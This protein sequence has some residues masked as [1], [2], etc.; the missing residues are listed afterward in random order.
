MN[1]NG[2]KM[3]IEKYYMKRYTS[4]KYPRSGIGRIS[5]GLQIKLPTS[6]KLYTLIVSN[7]NTKDLLETNTNY[8]KLNNTNHKALNN[9]N[10]F[11]NKSAPFYAILLS[12]QNINIYRTKPNNNPYNNST[13]YYS[14]KD[15][16]RENTKNELKFYVDNLYILNKTK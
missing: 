1:P 14:Y 8:P 2:P 3:I 5:I 15:Q 13:N 6:E 10:Y 9:N 4:S 12:P 11:K 16:L 7:Y